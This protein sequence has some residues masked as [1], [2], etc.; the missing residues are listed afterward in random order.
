MTAAPDET[1]DLLKRWAAGCDDAA[2]HLMSRVYPDLRRLAVRQRSASGLASPASDLA[3]ELCLR[4]LEQEAPR[5]KSRGHFFAVAARLVRRIVV[6][7]IRWHARQKRGSGRPDLDLD[8]VS[9]ATPGLDPDLV[10]LDQALGRLARV[11][12]SAVRVVELRYFAG[13]G[14]D[15]T[16]AT[17]GVGRSTVVRLWR[18][19]RAWLLTTLEG[20]RVA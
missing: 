6:D 3:Q 7:E 12:P 16:A 13:L 18:F 2:E 5:W 1:T 9:A 11:S 8:D 4:L 19:A 15:E 17:L 20:N 10:A 14:I